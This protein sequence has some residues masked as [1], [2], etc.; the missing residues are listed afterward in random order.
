MHRVMGAKGFTCEEENRESCYFHFIFS[1][2]SF[3][4]LLC[5][6]H[7]KMCDFHCLKTPAP[8]LHCI[9]FNQFHFIS[10][11]AKG[12]GGFTHLQHTSSKGL[13]ELLMHALP[14]DYAEYKNLLQKSLS[15]QQSFAYTGQKDKSDQLRGKSNFASVV[16]GIVYH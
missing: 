9:H 7:E 1:S 11:C 15:V 5:P 16:Q 10:Y 13:R 6:R 2:F 3:P 12:S 8:P 14:T 4:G